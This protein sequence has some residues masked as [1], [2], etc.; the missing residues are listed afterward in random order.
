LPIE[1][2]GSVIH[3]ERRQEAQEENAEAQAPQASTPYEIRPS[4]GLTIDFIVA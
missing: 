4:Q 1:T 3:V 2:G